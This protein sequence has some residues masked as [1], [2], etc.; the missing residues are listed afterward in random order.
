MRFAPISAA[1]DAVRTPTLSLL[2]WVMEIW[3][4]SIQ[5]RSASV[6]FCLSAWRYLI[7]LRPTRGPHSLVIPAEAPGE[8]E[9]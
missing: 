3:G 1:E 8:R 9:A 7:L 2:S 6:T 5:L 4:A